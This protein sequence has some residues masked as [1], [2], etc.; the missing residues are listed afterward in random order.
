MNTTHCQTM[1]WWENVGPV[2][3]DADPSAKSFQ[4]KIQYTLPFRLLS[5]LSCIHGIQDTYL[6]Q[7]TG[8]THSV[9]RLLPLGRREYF[10][11]LHPS[12]CFEFRAV[13]MP[14]S[15]VHHY[16][17]NTLFTSSHSNGF[18]GRKGP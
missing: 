14:S 2:Q 3:P 5:L 17:Q 8:S 15:S 11:I 6:L 1:N 18:L 10:H 12:V 9:F 13:P 16:K 7:D 4:R